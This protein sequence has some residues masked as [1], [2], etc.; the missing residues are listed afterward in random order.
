MGMTLTKVCIIDCDCS[1]YTADPFKD[2]IIN[3]GEEA[4]EETEGDMYRHILHESLLLSNDE[5]FWENFLKHVRS[6]REIAE[7][8][9]QD[10]G[11]VSLWAVVVKVKVNNYLGLVV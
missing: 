9:V 11:N 10:S 2:Y 8:D 7:E 5:A 4:E 1:Y 3:D 6:H